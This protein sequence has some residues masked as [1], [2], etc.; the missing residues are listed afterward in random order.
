MNV[1]TRLLALLALPLVAASLT[2]AAPAEASTN[3]LLALGDSYTEGVGDNVPG[4]GEG[5]APVAAKILGA[6]LTQD[7]RGGSGYANPTAYGAGIFDSR[8]YR[9]PAD[10]YRWVVI[11]GSTNDKKYLAA[12]PAGYAGKVNMTVRAAKVRYPHATV[13]VVGPVSVSGTTDAETL[14][15]NDTLRR[16]AAYNHVPFIDAVGEGWFKAG[17]VPSSW[18]RYSDPATGHPNDAAYTVIGQHV[19]ADIAG[20]R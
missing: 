7:G 1:H 11:Q 17:M 12:D 14:R 16:Y 8:L 20:L 2:V 3:D 10:S 5:W 19:A 15:I 18:S 9:H 13:V 4:N 6:R